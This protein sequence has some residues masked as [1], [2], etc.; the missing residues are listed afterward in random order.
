MVHS[1]EKT[2]NE[3]KSR[4]SP[5]YV[6]A[7][8]P[9]EYTSAELSDA[10]KKKL[11]N[12]EYQLVINPL[13]S[14]PEM[15]RWARELT[16][17]ATN[18]LQKA[19]FLFDKL[20]RHIDSSKITSSRTAMEVFEDWQKP[21]QRFVCKEYANIYVSLARAV[22]LKAF[23]VYVFEEVDG[24]KEQHA[25]AGVYIGD[26]CLLVDPASNWFGVPHRR[27]KVLDDIQTIAYHLS[28]HSPDVTVAR[29]AC[30]LAP[31][32]VIAQGNLFGQLAKNLDWSGA[33]EVMANVL[34]LDPESALAWGVRGEWAL[35][36]GKPDQALVNWQKA[37]KMNSAQGRWYLNI[38]Q[39][40]IDQGNLKEA[41]ENIRSG[42]RCGLDEEDL[43]GAQAAIAKINES[44]GSD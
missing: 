9:K 28:Q 11:T 40:Y 8:M 13:A 27:F 24:Q 17:G 29:L 39:I 34:K 22:G 20:T 19:S 4:L 36:E 37:V 41:R 18:D 23:W 16:A 43:I 15:D 32:S 1:F 33:S 12:E 44:I 21:E 26:R 30:K 42:L 38:A 7:P 31:D 6:T 35:H 10:L 3:L 2:L 5:V 14:T 25:C